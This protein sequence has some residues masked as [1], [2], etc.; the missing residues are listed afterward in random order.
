M[1]TASRAKLIGLVG[2]FLIG[3]GS[4]GF[5]ANEPLAIAVGEIQS[6]GGEQGFCPSET[7]RQELMRKLSDNSA[8]W[9]TTAPQPATP[10]A[11]VITGSITCSLE[12]QLRQ[13]G[14]PLF[15][16]QFMI[17]TAKVNLQLKLTNPTTGR[18]MATP[19]V[20]A[21]A[22]SETLVEDLG[23]PLSKSVPLQGDTLFPQATTSALDQVILQVQTTLNKRGE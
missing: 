3:L 9:V 18:V 14:F 21:Q 6:L 12:K 7:V 17:T 4:P 15:L 10:A 19:V 20:Q 2:V 8:Y 11:V 1:E 5:T 13:R 23:N 16:E 22:Q